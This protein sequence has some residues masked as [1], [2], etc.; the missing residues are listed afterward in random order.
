MSKHF[1]YFFQKNL[2]IFF[3]LS[4]SHLF[5][6]EFRFFDNHLINFISFLFYLSK[7][8]HDLLRFFIE[9]MI[10]SQKQF[11]FFPFF[12]LWFHC[13]Q[14]FLQLHSPLDILFK[15]I[16]YL[17]DFCI[18]SLAEDLHFRALISMSEL[19][20]A[21]LDDLGRREILN[22][23]FRFWTLAW[24][25]LETEIIKL[26][27]FHKLSIITR[28]SYWKHFSNKNSINIILLWRWLNYCRKS[29]IVGFGDR[30]WLDFLV[31]RH[32]WKIQEF[33]ERS[34]KWDQ[35]LYRNRSNKRV[36]FKWVMFF[37]E[38]FLS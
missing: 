35:L 10:V 13:L 15:L 19:Y 16:A 18:D 23:A 25:S 4:F 20:I 36:C 30:N 1:R 29:L 17:V 9:V 6:F 12:F 8:F 31:V 7:L 27:S 14:F 3:Y 5:R 21:G 28:L 32:N 24:W 26:L 38:K 2:F 33:Q 34:F 37:I 11:S 22:G